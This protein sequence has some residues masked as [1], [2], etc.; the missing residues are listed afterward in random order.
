[1]SN[2]ENIT[3]NQANEGYTIPP[4]PQSAQEHDSVEKSSP[5][6]HQMQVIRKDGNGVFFELVLDYVGIDKIGFGFSSYDKTKPK[7]SRQK[8]YIL[9][10]LDMFHAALIAHDIISGRY[11]AI[12]S[13]NKK[14]SP[15]QYP[16]AVLEVMRG[17]AYE[18]Q[19]ISRVLSLTPGDRKPWLLK[20]EQGAG[21][22]QPSGIISPAF[23]KNPDAS[24]RV[25]LTN[26]DLK[27]I[28]LA[29]KETVS[30]WT[31]HRFSPSVKHAF[32]EATRKE[33]EVKK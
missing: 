4:Q 15:S 16:P 33:S 26:D 22:K 27:E 20:A 23:G 19:A 6:Y 30:L 2:Q 11:A 5:V 13:K 21:T 1:M 28:A 10:Y 7:G 14:N 9:F 24:V 25:P 3:T 18:K 17:T 12:A 29:I 32:T 8:D 31:M